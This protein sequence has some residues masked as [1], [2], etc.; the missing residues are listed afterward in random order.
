MTCWEAWALTWRRLAYALQPRA[1]VLPATNALWERWNKLHKLVGTHWNQCVFNLH[2]KN[3]DVKSAWTHR[4]KKS[5][6]M[7]E[8]KPSFCSFISYYF[9]ILQMITALGEVWHPEHFVC[10]ACKMELSTTGFFEREGQPYC[11]KDYHQLFAPRCA[12]CKGPIMQVR[13]HIF[14]YCVLTM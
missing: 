10:V 13:K 1:T 7:K 8:I 9:P 6:L 14:V 4:T 11:D 3:Q 2:D 5:N 12:Y